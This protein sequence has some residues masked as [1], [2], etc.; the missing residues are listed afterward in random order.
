M[1]ESRRSGGGV[2]WFI[3]RKLKH[4]T[5]PLDEW[6]WYAGQ[7]VKHNWWWMGFSS[8]PHSS[9]MHGSP[10]W[11]QITQLWPPKSSGRCR[12]S[13]GLYNR[14]IVLL[15][16]P[17]KQS[18]HRY[19][20]QP[21]L[22]KLDFF[23]SGGTY[24]MNNQPSTQD[25]KIN[26]QMNAECVKRWRLS[27]HNQHLSEWQF[28]TGLFCDCDLLVLITSVCLIKPS[29]FTC[30]Y[31]SAQHT[32]GAFQGQPQRKPTMAPLFQGLVE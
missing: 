22:P 16:T 14:A 26:I 18:K 12:V 11:R 17:G 29:K 21:T 1:W 32:I 19:S 24:Q 27:T 4:L 20:A 6:I 9:R 2:V 30:I 7:P 3:F 15:L 5:K 28:F 23:Y 31:H 13:D 25:A 10:S 8:V